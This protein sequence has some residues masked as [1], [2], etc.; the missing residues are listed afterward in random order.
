MRSA[1]FR[2]KQVLI[3]ATDFLRLLHLSRYIGQCLKK[4]VDRV[5]R[6]DVVLKLEICFKP[7]L[8]FP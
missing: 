8:A 1:L 7:H 4:L 2:A 6:A 3:E 5:G